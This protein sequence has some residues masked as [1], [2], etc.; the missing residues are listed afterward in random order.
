[1]ASKKALLA[2]LAVLPLAAACG[3]SDDSTV[4][5][6]GSSP[7]TSA[8]S[9]GGGGGYDYGERGDYGATT[10]KLRTTSLGT[11]LTDSNGRT[12]YLFE[13]DGTDTSRCSGACAA[14]WPPVQATDVGSGLQASMLT[15]VSRSD[16][17][18]QSSYGGHPLYYYA[19]DSGPGQTRGQ[20]LDQFG[21]EWYVID[22]HGEKIDSD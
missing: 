12:L 20:G 5:A 2:V 21:A 19:G 15:Q 7:T 13:K 6:G 3:S 8:S 22:A 10:L 17:T 4:S 1:M 9:D 18:K 14:A 16:G 11:F